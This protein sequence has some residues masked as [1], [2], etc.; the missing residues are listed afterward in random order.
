MR[1]TNRNHVRRDSLSG[2]TL[3]EL[4]VVIA[5]IA[6][7]AAMLLPALARSKLKATQANCLSNQKQLDLGLIMYGTDFQDMIVP[8]PKQAN[9]GGQAM[10]GYIYV[11]SMTWDLAAQSADVSLQNWMNCVKSTANPFF[12]FVPN[13]MAIHCPGDTRAGRAPGSGW[14]MDSYSKP[15]GMAGEAGSWGGTIYTKLNQVASPSQ[16]FAFREDCD[17]R[18]FCWGTWVVQWSTA[19]M[20]GH[21]QSFTWVDPLPM[22]HGNVSTAGFVDGHAEYHKW[23][24]GKMINYGKS[25]ANGGP[26]NPPNPPMAGPDY[27]YVYNGY[28]FPTWTP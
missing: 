1:M 22:Y 10:N 12:G 7:L 13:P 6:I 25:V 3:I 24:D 8:W 14:A 16:T 26:L 4:L 19:P 9:G 5:I 15:N 23:L 11:A 21:S 2:F 18:G 27:D 17:S 20:F 28:R